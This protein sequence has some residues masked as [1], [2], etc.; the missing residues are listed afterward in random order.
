M[1]TARILVI[2]DEPEITDILDTFLTNA[3]HTVAAENSA[4]KGIER[5][6]SFKPDM[7]FLDIMMPEMDGYEI[8]QALKKDPETENIPVVFLT[9]KDTTDDQGKSFK[10]GGDMFVKKPFVCERLLEVVNLVLLSLSK[11]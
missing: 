10:S 8:C 11:V 4:T 1:R 3:G 7:V 5:A 6:K 9:G 2:D